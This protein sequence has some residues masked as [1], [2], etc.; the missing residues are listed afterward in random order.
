MPSSSLQFVISNQ[1]IRE[2]HTKARQV[3]PN[4]AFSY[5]LGTFTDEVMCVKEIFYPTN[6]DFYCRPDCVLVQDSWFR[7]VRRY[8]NKNG[9]QLVAEFHSHPYTKS[10]L[11]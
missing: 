6:V 9:L 11:N 3:F 8:A 1:I 2:L 4:E 5:L 10:E 7:E